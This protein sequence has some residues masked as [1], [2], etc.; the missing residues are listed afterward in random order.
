MKNNYLYTLLAI[1]ACF[2][3]LTVQAQDEV[4][5][6]DGSRYLDDKFT[7][8]DLVT[9]K[10][11]KNVNVNGDSVELYLDIYTPHGDGLTRRPAIVFQ[12]GGSFISGDKSDMQPFCEF[13]ARKGFVAVSAQ[14]RLVPT[15]GGNPPVDKYL[16]GVIKAIGDFK[17]A[18]RHM[19]KSVA[20]GNPYGIDSNFVF[21]GGIS[22]GAI[23]ALCMNYMT[24][25]DNI[26]PLITLVINSNGG[27][28]GNTGGPNSLNYT[29]KVRGIINM[30]GALADT[31]WIKAG[32]QPLMSYHGDKDQ[33]VPFG[34]GV[35][36]GI[37]PF[38]GSSLLAQRATNL[39]IKNFFVPVPG[40]GHTDIYT[41]VKYLDYLTGY[42]DGSLKLIHSIICPNTVIG[43]NDLSG[44]G[45][46]SIYPNPASAEVFVR[47]NA[48][49]TPYDIALSDITGRQV[50]FYHNIGNA[51]FRIDRSAIGKGMYILQIKNAQSGQ[52]IGTGKLVFD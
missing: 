24:P 12:H 13:L 40:G 33:V 36:S 39:N 3:S 42:F 41:D 22:A 9:V 28:E 27:F 18:V 44:N 49:T 51:D 11:G 10:Y 25:D 50:A 26:N 4:E 52:L 37:L 20:E 34:F 19:K 32:D 15:A 23:S 21:A 17:A 45:K 7:S 46:V 35:L 1:A 38:Y 2:F 48:F 5:G 16:D 30:S 29:S 31:T 43:T 6:C 47:N 14:Y 8:V